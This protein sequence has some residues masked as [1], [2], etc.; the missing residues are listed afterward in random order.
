MKQEKEKSDT[1]TGV[2]LKK[3]RFK[4]FQIQ[5][6]NP[7]DFD[8]PCRLNKLHMHVNKNYDLEISTIKNKCGLSHAVINLFVI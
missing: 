2:N 3:I 7:N 1:V 8:D 4:H 5:I 6:L